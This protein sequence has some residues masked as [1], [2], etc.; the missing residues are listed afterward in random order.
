MSS[1]KSLSKSMQPGGYPCFV[2]ERRSSADLGD[3][4]TG[5]GKG[6]DERTGHILQGGAKHP[7]VQTKGSE[8]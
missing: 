4:Y 8:K 1:N 2:V 5:K 3:K 6:H 7:T